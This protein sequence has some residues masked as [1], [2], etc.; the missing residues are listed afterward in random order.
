MSAGA[1]IEEPAE[2]PNGSDENP[3]VGASDPH[4]AV[5]GFNE[6]VSVPSRELE[7]SVKSKFD[8]NCTGVPR[9]RVWAAHPGA[10]LLQMSA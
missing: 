2:P 5:L 8:G 6:G 4:P 9:G 1:A 3:K 7:Y 10:V